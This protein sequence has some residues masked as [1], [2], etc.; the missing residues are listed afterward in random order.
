MMQCGGTNENHENMVVCMMGRV[1]GWFAKG[2]NSI[3]LFSIL[4]VV[5]IMDDSYM[6]Q[7]EGMD[8]INETMQVVLLAVW[9]ACCVGKK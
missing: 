2:N 4:I 3:V 1:H 7:S 8:G 5:D 9:R 6:L